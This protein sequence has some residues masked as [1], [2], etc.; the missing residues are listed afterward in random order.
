MAVSLY[1]VFV[2]IICSISTFIA[3]KLIYLMM[4]NPFFH[5][6]VHNL[7]NKVFNLNPGA[8]N[9]Q[10]VVLLCAQSVFRVS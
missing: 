6:K 3:I 4:T 2:G 9:V 10:L 7:L 1:I 8:S 5:D